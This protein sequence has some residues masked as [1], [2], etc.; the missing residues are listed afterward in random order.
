MPHLVVEYFSESAFDREA[1]LATALETAAGSGLMLREDIK[2]RLVPSEAIL[3][4]DG[5]RSFVHVTIS[6]LE[7]RSPDQKL[8]LATAVTENL[9]ALC[10]SIEAI[11][12]D[13]RDMNSYCY[14]KSLV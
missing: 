4:G 6:M 12:T 11:S 3:F 10:H 7:G 14:K 2:V 8:K 13:I 5:R 1:V 9:R